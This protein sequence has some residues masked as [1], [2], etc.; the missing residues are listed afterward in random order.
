MSGN[1][2]T[3]SYSSLYACL[4]KS[5][6]GSYS[7]LYAC[8]VKPKLDHTVLCMH[9][10]ASRGIKSE[11]CVCGL[12]LLAPV[13]LLR[14]CHLMSIM[15]VH[16]RIFVLRLSSWSVTEFYVPWLAWR[17]VCCVLRVAS[18]PSLESTAV[19]CLNEHRR[20][21]QERSSYSYKRC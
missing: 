18:K 1:T 20:Q 7:T 17:C 5:Q 14:S 19:T 10:R 21:T 11:S 13:K 9:V 6:I 16:V 8:L 15:R 2:Q 3:G 12:H 4:V